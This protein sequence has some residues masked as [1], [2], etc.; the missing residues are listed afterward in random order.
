MICFF[1]QF[2][3]FVYHLKLLVPALSSMKNELEQYTLDHPLEFFVNKANIPNQELVNSTIDYFQSGPG[4]RAFETL[5][6]LNLLKKQHDFVLSEK[7]NPNQALTHLKE[8]PLSNLQRHVLFGFLLKWFG[9]YPVNNFDEQLDA[10]LK[11]IETLFLSYQ[12]D[13]PEKK[14][15][16][17]DVATNLKFRQFETIFNTHFRTGVPVEELAKVVFKTEQKQP[18]EMFYSF[19]HLYY[20]AIEKAIIPAP[21]NV[22]SEA[23]RYA[24]LEAGFMEWLIAEREWH[25]VDLN[26]LADHLTMANFAEYIKKREKQQVMPPIATDSIHMPATSKIETPVQSEKQAQKTTSEK[27]EF[28]FVTYSWESEEHNEKVTAFTDLLRKKGY[29]AEMDLLTLQEQTAADLQQMM[30]QKIFNATKVIIVLT[31]GYKMKAE[32]YKGGVGIEYKIISKDIEDHDRKYILVTFEPYN[33]DLVPFAFKKRE[34]INVTTTD[35][36]E[37][38]LYK[39]DD[40]PKF[41]FSPV[42]PNREEIK[43]KAIP[44]FTIAEKFSGEQEEVADVGPWDAKQVRQKLTDAI[45]DNSTEDLKNT[46][47]QNSF[48]FYELVSRKDMQQP[49]FYSVLLHNEAVADF[50]WLNDNSDGPEWVLVKIAEP[51]MAV[52]EG[53]FPSQSLSRTIEGVKLW[54]RYFAGNPKAANDIFGAVSRFRLIVIA[55]TQSAWQKP[56]AIAWR[57]DNNKNATVEVRSSGVFFKSLEEYEKRPKDFWGPRQYPQ[58]IPASELQT[59]WQS[60]GYMQQM[61]HLLGS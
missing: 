42:N 15:C 41:A 21:T 59:Y 28:V 19:Q 25:P 32:N 48:L 7:A 30:Y 23:L 6:F 3:Y 18:P 10:T 39:L 60:Y 22:Y 26:G 11:Q 49:I 37:S 57:G 56:T 4:A 53:K 8:I 27:P 33:D 61:I 54:D 5:L 40:V 43:P 14:F 24:E 29:N 13:T 34:V 52:M 51:S 44:K 2:I 45:A 58:T 1:L 35:G 20:G 16:R 31:K 17:A 38:L 46:L 36:M 47:I 55:G 12:E 50:V 9:G